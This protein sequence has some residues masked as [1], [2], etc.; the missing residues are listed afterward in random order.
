MML[1]LARRNRTRAVLFSGLR[2]R[3]AR[4]DLHTADGRQFGAPRPSERAI[5]ATMKR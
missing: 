2:R 5:Q 4:L 3:L 1:P